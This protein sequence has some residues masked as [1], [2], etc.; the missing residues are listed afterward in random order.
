MDN[1]TQ[2]DERRAHE[3]WREDFLGEEEQ[4]IQKPQRMLQNVYGN[5]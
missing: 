1:E 4:E 5:I 3:G 2:A